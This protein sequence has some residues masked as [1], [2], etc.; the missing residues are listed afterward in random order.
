MRLTRNFTLR[1]LAGSYAAER[2]GIDNTPPERV[3]ERLPLQEELRVDV[4]GVDQRLAGGDRG[5]VPLRPPI[6]RARSGTGAGAISSAPMTRCR[7]PTTS[8]YTST[9]AVSLG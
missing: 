1:E 2:L 7:P 3:L 4:P 5:W 9:A 8:A 6:S